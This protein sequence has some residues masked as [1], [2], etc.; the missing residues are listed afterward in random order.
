MRLECPRQWQQWQLDVLQALPRDT[1]AHIAVHAFEAKAQRISITG[2][3][4]DLSTL[5][6]WSNA[7]RARWSRGLSVQLLH[8]QRGQTG[9]IQFELV[10]S[11]VETQGNTLGVQP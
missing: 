2:A 5:A 3:S 10:L 11:P 6:A 1:T 4:S 8:T 7:V 9:H